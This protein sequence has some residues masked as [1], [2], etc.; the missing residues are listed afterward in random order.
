MR[1]LATISLALAG[2]ALAFAQAPSI[3]ELGPAASYIPTGFPGAGIA[4][5][6]YFYIKGNNLGPDAGVVFSGPAAYTIGVD[7]GGTRVRVTIGSTILDAFPYYASATQVNVILPSVT[8]LGPG[9]VTVFYNGQ[10][11]VFPI[12]VV[13]AAYGIFT[14]N[15]AGT[16]PAVVTNAVTNQVVT[17]INALHP[18]DRGTLWGT[19]L[20]AVNFADNQP[21]QFQRLESGVSLFIGGQQATVEYAGRTPGL[22]GLDQ[23]NFIVPAGVSGCGVPIVVRIANR[24]SN[25][26]TIAVAASGSVCSDADAL[27]AADWTAVQAGPLSVGAISLNRFITNRTEGEQIIETR[28]DALTGAFTRSTFDVLLRGKPAGA[29]IGACMVS[30]YRGSSEPAGAPPARLDAGTRLTLT[31]LGRAKD[32]LKTNG[33]YTVVGIGEAQQGQAGGVPTVFGVPGPFL[34][35]GNYTLSGPGGADVGAFTASVAL[36]AALTWTNQAAITSVARSADLRVAWSGTAAS[37]L[38]L[39]TGST[40][41]EGAS[42]GGSFTCYEAASKGEFTIP[43]YVLSALPASSATAGVPQAF[44]AVGNYAVASR[45]NATGLNYGL[46]T[47]TLAQKSVLN[48]E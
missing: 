18:G 41:N 8:P 4:Q 26:A 31:G 11:A 24:P 27:S 19:G 48:F 22:S 42:V 20:G 17:A 28:S 47:Y 45:F 7:L 40:F 25:F 29:S 16:G 35:A 39:I 3:T 44:L 46:F 2:A 37:E 14:L 43:A 13:R 10:Q 15:S 32:A 34:D 9:T 36:P 23:I 5:G 1:S 21:A 6:S 30:L 38:V 12:T 33:I